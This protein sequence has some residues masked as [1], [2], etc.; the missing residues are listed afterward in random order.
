M[1]HRGDHRHGH[2]DHGS[3][4]PLE[5]E[6]P[7]VFGGPSTATNDDHV[8][9]R[10]ASGCRVHW[11]SETCRD[12][13]A[14]GEL[15]CSLLAGLAIGY[16]FFKREARQESPELCCNIT[17]SSK[18]AQE[19]EAPKQ[20]KEAEQLLSKDHMDSSLRCCQE[21]QTTD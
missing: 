9:G 2:A 8:N 7:Q 19:L 18:S 21:E 10:H 11:V 15:L 14:A 3:S 12:P 5:V 4:H 6:G 1:A 17:L 20:K 13:Q 16:F